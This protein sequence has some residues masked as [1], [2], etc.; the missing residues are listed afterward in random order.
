MTDDPRQNRPRRLAENVAAYLPDEAAGIAKLSISLPRELLDDVRTAADRHGSTV[1]ATI[2][3]ALRKAGEP[4]VPAAEDESRRRVLP[5]RHWFALAGLAR[6]RGQSVEDALA[7][8]VDDWLAAQ[9][10]RLVR[11]DAWRR[12]F[13][14]FL[15]RRSALA[16]QNVWTDE[17]IQADVDAAVEEA[18]AARRR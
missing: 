18:R 14:E 8:A 11:D 13:T 16:E 2:A 5:D 10:V 12:G 6:I 17:E 3:A 9:G 1:S 4:N 15:A 7:E